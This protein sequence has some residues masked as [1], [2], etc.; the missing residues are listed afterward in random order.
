MEKKAVVFL[1]GDIIKIIF[2]ESL[3]CIPKKEVNLAYNKKFFEQVFSQFKVF[4]VESANELEKG[5]FYTWLSLATETEITPESKSTKQAPINKK[6]AEIIGD[7][8]DDGRMLFRSTEGTTIIIDDLPT[9]RDIP[10]MPGIK[11]TLAIY[12]YRAIDLAALSPDLLKK[13]SYLKRL[14]KDG[15]LIPCTIAEARSMQEEYDARMRS[16]ND[17]RLDA[18]APILNERAEDFV[19]RTVSGKLN[20]HEAE[21]INV[22]DGSPL[23]ASKGEISPSDLMKMG[24]M[25]YEGVNLQFTGQNDEAQPV[26]KRQLMVRPQA[27]LD[28]LKPKGIARKQGKQD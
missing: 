18:V 12:P 19:S 1:D 14:I 8:E 10:G 24:S 3:K 27:S 4:M 22:D 13:S 21:T 23:D 26:V 20:V 6:V 17:A 11:E 15:K 25:T 5:S 7:V 16:E 2:G 9:G 28:G